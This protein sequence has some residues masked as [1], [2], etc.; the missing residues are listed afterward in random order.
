MLSNF[1]GNFITLVLILVLPI[2]FLRAS[3]ARR[4]TPMDLSHVQGLTY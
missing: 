4:G 1:E 3:S 2:E